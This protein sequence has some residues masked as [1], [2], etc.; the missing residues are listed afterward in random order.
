MSETKLPEIND[1][2]DFRKLFLTLWR[3]K[4]IIF[5]ISVLAIVLSSLYLRSSERKYSVQAVFKPVVEA[6]GG[7]NLP[8]FSG[9]ASMAGISLPSSSGSDFKT[10]QKLIF[11]EEVAERIFT[12]KELVV[13]LFKGEWN[14]DTQ[15]FKAP[16]SGDIGKLKQAELSINKAIE[17][18]PDY[19]QAHSNLGTILREIGKL[20]EAE[21]STRKAI[22]IKPNYAEAH[23]KGLQNSLLKQN[24]AN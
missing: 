13:K 19:A 6:S 17:I 7:P 18:K 14:S 10:Y 9:L 12:N 16:Q 11:S 3:G 22:E 21:L 1:E 5:L 8:G 4:Y 2:I 20:K 15:S 23:L 24:F